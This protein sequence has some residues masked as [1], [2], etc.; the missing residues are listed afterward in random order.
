VESVTETPTCS[1]EGE[2]RYRNVKNER[3]VKGDEELHE[4][5]G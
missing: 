3:K 2:M 4:K 5:V 1:I